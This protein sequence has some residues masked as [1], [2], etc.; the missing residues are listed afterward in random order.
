MEKAVA[1][2]YAEGLLGRT[3]STKKGLDFDIVPQSWWQAVRGCEE[4]ALMESLEGKRGVPRIK[5]PFPAVVGL[6]LRTH[7][8][9]CRPS[10]VHPHSF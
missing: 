2:A 7:R 3:S 10:P 4:S 6:V 1:D 5:P 8:F 9:I